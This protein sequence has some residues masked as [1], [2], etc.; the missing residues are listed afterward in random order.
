MVRKVVGK[1]DNKYFTDNVE[2]FGGKA[3]VHKL[4]T[5]KYWY[6]RTWLDEERHHLRRSLRTTDLDE[7]IGKAEKLFIEVHG[8]VQTGKKYFGISFEELAE[9]FLEFQKGR[10]ETDKITKGR[11]SVLR[12]QITRHVLPYIKAKTKVGSITSSAFYDYAQYR[13]KKSKGVQEVTIRNEYTTIGAFL[14]FAARR[15]YINFPMESLNFEEIKITKGQIGRRD[16]FT[17]QEYDWLSRYGLPSWAKQEPQSSHSNMMPL[18]RKQFIR[19]QILIM[20]NCGLRVGE[21]RQ[22]RWHM[23][24][25]RKYDQKSKQTLVELDLPKEIVKT[26]QARKILCR[27]GQYFKRIREYS[28]WIGK[29]NLVFGNNDDGSPISKSEYYRLWA[30]LMKF[31]ESSGKI[32]DISKRKLS[33][34]SMRHFQITARLYAQVSVFDVSQ[35]A[36]T[37]VSHIESHYGH[38]DMTKQRDN[39]LKSY[40]YDEYGYVEPI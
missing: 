40:Q 7:A 35:M 6:F 32:K 27:G 25:I 24:S 1:K 12:T 29:D 13:R 8:K 10:V 4:P 39:A 23:V 21:A 33:Y 20:A 3:H 17:P 30:D 19:D 16:T 11:W 9:E 36:G 38:V 37:S 31:C 5:S 28:N 22:L 34:Y 15:G 18:K 2:I 26:R 14:K